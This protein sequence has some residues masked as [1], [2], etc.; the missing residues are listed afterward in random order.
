[1]T[2]L[3][4]TSTYFRS[5]LAKLLRSSACC[6]QADAA[7]IKQRSALLLDEFH[8]VLTAWE[9]LGVDPATGAVYAEPKFGWGRAMLGSVSFWLHDRAPGG[10]PSVRSDSPVSSSWKAHLP[11]NGSCCRTPGWNASPIADI[12]GGEGEG[13]F[14]FR[15]GPCDLRR[16]SALDRP[17]SVVM[18][19]FEETQFQGVGRHD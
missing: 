16:R 1:M 15:S 4:P 2:T 17:E 9:P 3:G 6:G 5:R 18:L 12:R 13:R 14:C 7:R 19:A 8:A 10:A 11:A